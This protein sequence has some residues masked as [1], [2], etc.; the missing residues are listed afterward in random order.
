MNRYKE[1]IYEELEYDAPSK[2]IADIERL[3]AERANALTLLKDLLK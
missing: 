3:D 1:V 2:I